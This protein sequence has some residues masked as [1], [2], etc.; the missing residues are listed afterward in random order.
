MNEVKDEIFKHSTCR[1]KGPKLCIGIWALAED[2][3][4]SEDE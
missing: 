2:V 3:G 4:W 1:N